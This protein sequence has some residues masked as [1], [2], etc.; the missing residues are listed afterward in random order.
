MQ[1]NKLS[2]YHS[3]LEDEHPK[4]YRPAVSPSYIGRATTPP[5][6]Q[7]FCMPSKT[8]LDCY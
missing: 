1:L 6:H 8:S 7:K 4:D 5:P 2:R 3:P